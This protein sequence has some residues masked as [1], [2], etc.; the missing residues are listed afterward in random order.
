MKRI[1]FI[2]CIITSSFILTS[3]KTAIITSADR[4]VSSSW[5]V[6]TPAGLSAELSFDKKSCLASL[7]IIDENDN[8]SVI[9]GVFAIDSQNIYIT[10]A[11]FGKTYCFGY[12][13]YSDR[14]ELEYDDTVLVFN[15]AEK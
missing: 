8:M 14:L 11:E 3:C 4:A 12:K 2:L 9:E 7:L 6:S 13:A 1:L 15:A 5:T 10:S